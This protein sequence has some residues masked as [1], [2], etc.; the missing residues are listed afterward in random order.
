MKENLSLS[1]V[2]KNLEEKLIKH[3][4]NNL[5]EEISSLL[6]ENF[7]EFGSSGKIYNKKQTIEA[8]NQGSEDQIIINDFKTTLLTGEVVLVTYTAVR[9]YIAGDRNIKS[10]RSSVWKKLDGAWKICFHQGT[11]LENI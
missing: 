9:T 4:N 8:L 3:G 7:I 6:S 2:I 10:L 5:P 1:E 11:L